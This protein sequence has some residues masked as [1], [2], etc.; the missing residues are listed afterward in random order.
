MWSNLK[1]D[2]V[3]VSSVNYNAGEITTGVKL[4]EGAFC[5]VR[6]IIS[7]ALKREKKEG[8]DDEED[9]KI[10][11]ILPRHK[12]R[13]STVGEEVDLEETDEADFPVN[14]FKT[15]SEIRSYMSKVYFR[16]DEEGKHARYALKQ[17]KPNEQQKHVEQGLI[18]LSIE[19]QFLSCLDHPNIIKMRGVVGTSLTQ[20]FGIILDRLYM[21]LEDKMDFWVNERN[22]AARAGMCGCFGLGKMDKMTS[23]AIM[24]SAI[25]IAYDLSCAMR[26][27]HSKKWDPLLSVACLTFWGDCFIFGTFI[28]MHVIVDSLVYRDTK[29]ENAGFDVRGDIKVC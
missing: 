7:I 15:K 13:S 5:D 9:D 18:D 14:I 19:A 6:E 10:D 27:I 11:C 2:V 26:Y 16:E 4:G 23:D 21:T 17:L 28:L 25:T 12:R 1:S 29:P 22:D 3:I 20:D 8:V 24:F